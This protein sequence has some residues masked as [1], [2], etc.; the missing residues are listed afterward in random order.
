MNR[1]IENNILFQKLLDNSEFIVC[2]D[3]GANRLLKYSDKIK[4][5]Y[6][7][8]DLDSIKPEVKSF[9]ENNGA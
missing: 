6:I 2:A 5:D 1:P 9:Y 4:V 8:G 7:I 3:G